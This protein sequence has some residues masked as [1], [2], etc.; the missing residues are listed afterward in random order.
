MTILAAI[1]REERKLEKKTVGKLQNKLEGVRA[2][3]F[4]FGKAWGIRP[5]G[6]RAIGEKKRVLSEVVERRVRK[7]PRK[8]VG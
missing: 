6:S 3:F 7:Q 5:G 2:A 1:K 8:R 4:F